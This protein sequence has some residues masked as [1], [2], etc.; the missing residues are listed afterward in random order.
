M[1]I[2]IP[3]SGGFSQSDRVGMNARLSSN[4]EGTPLSPFGDVNSDRSYARIGVDTNDNS[5][6]FEMRSPSGP[7]NSTMCGRR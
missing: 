7:Q 3:S 1:W 4:Y 5:R 6:D 2:G